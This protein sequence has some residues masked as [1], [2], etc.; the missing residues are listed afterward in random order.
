MNNELSHL[1]HTFCFKIIFYI[2]I[3][4]TKTA[5]RYLYQKAL[6]PT[7]KFYKILCEFTAQNYKFKMG[8]VQ[9][10]QLIHIYLKA[11]NPPNLKKNFK[12]LKS[13]NQIHQTKSEANVYY[14]IR[15]FKVCIFKNKTP[16][17]EVVLFLNI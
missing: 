9:Q 11:K 5:I 12:P 16:L 4:T 10:I 8:F 2:L 7:N 13:T 15:Y 14:Y 17:R 1:S 3:L 6:I